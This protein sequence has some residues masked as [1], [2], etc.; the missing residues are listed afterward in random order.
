[1]SNKYF[2]AMIGPL[3]QGSIDN[4][5]NSFIENIDH[6]I[7][8]VN[9]CTSQ[10]ITEERFNLLRQINLIDTLTLKRMLDK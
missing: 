10:Y 8:P 1:M 9:I 2:V 4:E 5:Y 6:T 7:T 3:K